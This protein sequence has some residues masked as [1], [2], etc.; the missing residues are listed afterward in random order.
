M[1]PR[2]KKIVFTCLLAMVVA[3]GFAHYLTPG[4]LILFHDTFRR[5]SYFPIVIGAIIY[6]VWGGLSMAV[7]S[8]LSFVPHL[9]M[10]WY[11]GPETYYSELSEILFYLAAGLV[12]GMIS[13][14]ENRLRAKYQ[15]LS[16][17]LAASYKRLHSQAARLVQAEKE[18][19]EAGKLSL[20]GHVSA[21]L[22]HEIKNPLTGIKT[23]AQVISKVVSGPPFK[24]AYTGSPDGLSNLV[25]L[26]G[27]ISAEADRV[28]RILNDLLKLGKPGEPNRTYFD[29]SQIVHKALGLL[30]PRFDKKGI[31]RD[32]QVPC[33]GVRA[34]PDKILQVLIN[35]LLNARDAVP[36]HGGQIKIRG[37]TLPSGHQVLKICDNGPGIA[38]D[39][40]QHIF[41]PFFSLKKEGTG[42]G[43]SVVYS[44][45]KQNGVQIQADSP[46]GQG[47]AFTL[48]FPGPDRA[49]GVT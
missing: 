6:G 15:S 10:F 17:Q 28:T 12:I 36:N 19:G 37:N 35:L 49:G 34:D 38:G 7:L 2:M 48:T 20:L 9:L 29:L 22:A 13:S 45:L 1:T 43:L 23:S 47:M 24:A 25:E 4:H 18:L 33:L 26:S 11:Q 16:E 27:N 46:A 39:K 44:L 42:L 40:I 21:S 30:G 41:D 5:L 32:A 8:C 3:I 14:R 31:Q